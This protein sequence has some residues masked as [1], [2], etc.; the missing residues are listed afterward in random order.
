[1]LLAA[2]SWY[3]SDAPLALSPAAELEAIGFVCFERWGS[4][5]EAGAGASG[6]RLSS[7]AFGVLG[8]LWNGGPGKVQQA[9]LFGRVPERR[10]RALC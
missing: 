7:L 6:V 10:S 8:G 1:M 4:S 2:F 5:W 3:K 9:R